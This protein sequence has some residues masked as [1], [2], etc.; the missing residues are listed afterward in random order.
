MWACSRQLLYRLLAMG[1]PTR[2]L[3]PLELRALTMSRQSWIGPA[4]LVV[5][6]ARRGHL[7]LDIVS[8]G[9]RQV[10]ACSSL[11]PMSWMRKGPPFSSGPL[12]SIVFHPAP[13]IIQFL[14]LFT[15]L[16]PVLGATPPSILHQGL[17][18]SHTVSEVSNEGEARGSEVHHSNRRISC[19]VQLIIAHS[20]FLV[21]AFASFLIVCYANSNT[22]TRPCLTEVPSFRNL[23]FGR[24]FDC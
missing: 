10:L 9:L 24:R 1:S 6:Y 14:P 23:A 4:F 17:S 22:L 18:F 20:R 7:T 5:A 13:Y 2:W 21:Q 11:L 3:C 8:N 15:Q 12:T 19:H 16:Q